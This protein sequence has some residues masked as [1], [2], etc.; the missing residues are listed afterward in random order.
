MQEE[1]FH[2]LLRD[3]NLMFDIVFSMLACAGMMA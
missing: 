1:R 3:R 2:T